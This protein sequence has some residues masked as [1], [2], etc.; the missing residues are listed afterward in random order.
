MA[1]DALEV[2]IQ[3]IAAL[4]EPL[5]RLRSRDRRLAQ[6]A[7]DALNSVGLNLDEGRRRGGRDRIQHWHVAFGSAGELQTALR[8]AEAWGYLDAASLAPARVL[9]DRE[10]A[11]CWRLT[12]GR[13]PR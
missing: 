11:M 3:L 12:R 6:Q 4:R 10:L 8:Q 2:A 7:T 9:L 5:Q 1:F 13:P